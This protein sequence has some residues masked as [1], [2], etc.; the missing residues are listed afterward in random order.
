[1]S[2]LD[3]IAR[4]RFTT[5]A[6]ALPLAAS[7]LL[8]MA[9]V[10]AAPAQPAPLPDTLL[11]LDRAAMALFDAAESSDWAQAAQALDRARTAAEGVA[12]LQ[13]AFVE[14]GG[15]QHRF[16][17]A[18]NDLG[19]D[20]IETKTALSV[21]DPRWLAS[22]AGRIAAHAGELSQ[23]FATR[24]HA[25]LPRV[26]AL[27]FLARNM[28]Q[29]LLW[30][31]NNGFDM[32]QGDFNQLWKALKGQLTAVPAARVRALDDAL[33][34]LALSRSAATARQLYDAVLAI[35]VASQ[36]L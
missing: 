5:L 31:D 13:A 9:A 32:A 19:S 6:A 34:K 23:P 15:E 22:T 8:P 29:A 11:A 2:G 36:S 3:C 20:L 17:Q 30:Q 26:L 27:M 12:P 10:A 16:M 24:A 14:A 18:R 21:R 7:A 1:M 25:L 35:R 33:A 28:R 4:R